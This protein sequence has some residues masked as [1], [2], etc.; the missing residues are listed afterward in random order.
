M[1][2][3]LI[4]FLLA[5]TA[6]AGCTADT[7]WPGMAESQQA[8]GHDGQDHDGGHTGNASAA[9]G[10]GHGGMAGH[11]QGGMQ[12]PGFPAGEGSVPTRD[13]AADFPQVSRIRLVGDVDLE[14]SGFTTG[15]GTL[16]DPYVIE[17]VYVAGDL[18]IQDT[19]ACFIVRETWIGGQ[20]TLNWNGQCVHV[21]HN[22]VRDLRVNENIRRVGYATGGFIEDN[23]IEIVGQLRH[24]DGVFQRNEVGPA[25]ADSLWDQVLETTPLLSQRLLIANIDGFN[26]GLI[27]DNT[28]HGSVDLDFHGHHHGA[29]FFAPHSHYHG[30]DPK[31]YTL[32]DH[33]HTERWTS[34]E[35][36]GNIV[37]DREGYGLRYEDRNHAGDDRTAR[38]E[39][40]EELD[41]PHFHRTDVVISGNEVRGA[42]IWVDVFNADDSRHE[43]R[44]DG[45]LTIEDNIVR[46]EEREEEIPFFSTAYQP[47]VGFQIDLAKEVEIV[48][49]GNQAFYL[50][51]EEGG[52]PLLSSGPVVSGYEVDRLKDAH[53]VVEDNRADGFDIGLHLRSFEDVSWR[54]SGN[55]FGDAEEPVR[56]DDSVP[57]PE[58]G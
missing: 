1:R 30:D 57:E 17:H 53:L 14:S 38:S 32:H 55:D 27:R 54:A 16:Q 31:N 43:E 6:L 13:E 3:I 58:G 28:F 5:A 24:Y 44:N 18:Y 7:P 23:E 46:V 48:L 42:G 40:V 36:T 20:L 50:P 29:G 52:L 4:I 9:G 35:F 51:A 56:S 34:V 19:D 10:G 15:N 33:D 47:Y 37:I 49:R 8:A 22:H 2:A 39:Q 26:Q 12:R 45:W 25:S 21:H 41:D 11:Q